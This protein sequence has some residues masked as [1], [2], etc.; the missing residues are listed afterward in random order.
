M[1]TIGQNVRM[2]RKRRRLTTTKVAKLAGI[3]R[4]R[5]NDLEESPNLGCSSVTLWKLAQALNY[6]MERFLEGVL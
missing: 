6:P 1:R 5:L 3:S 4:K 2:L